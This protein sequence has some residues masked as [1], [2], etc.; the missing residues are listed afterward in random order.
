MVAAAAAGGCGSGHVLA[1]SYPLHE[2][3]KKAP[4][5][6]SRRSGSAGS[7]HHRA[8]NSK[9]D[10]SVTRGAVPLQDSPTGFNVVQIPRSREVGQSYLTSVATTLYSL[11][12]AFRI[13]L[14][15]RP[16]LVRHSKEG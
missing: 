16:E 14:R 3:I 11:A 13:V 9:L 8:C 2:A 1:H 6:V 12:F 4:A 10:V 15:E 5:C 7:L